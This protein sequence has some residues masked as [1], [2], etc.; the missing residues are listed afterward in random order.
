M[1]HLFLG[2]SALVAM[3]NA[4]PAAADT[5]RDSLI[6]AYETNP[7]L[8][9]ERA[10]LRAT[11]E[12][13]AQA[14]AQGRI[15]INASGSYEYADSEF[16]A[17]AV[18]NRPF[19]IAG[20]QQEETFSR[21]ITAEQPVFR[22]FR[23]LNA[24]RQA[25]AAIDAG[26]ANLL[27]VE[28]QVL[29]DGVTAYMDVLRDEAV[30]SLRENNVAVLD[31]QRQASKD[32]FEVGEVTRTDVAQA[33][34]RLA[35]AKAE[36]IAARANL[37]V[38]RAAFRRVIGNP[39][40]TLSPPPP[41]PELPETEEAAQA[42]ADQL[43]PVILTARATEVSS[44]RAVDVAKGALLPTLSARVEWSRAEEQVLANSVSDRTALIGQ[45][46]V[47]IFQ[48]GV[49]HSNVRQAKQQNSRDRMQIVA[50]DRDVEEQVRN[51][52]E[53]LAAARAA[54]LSSKE[55]VRANEIAFEGVEQEAQV[56]SRTTLDVLDAEQELLDSRVQLVQVERDEYVAGFALV[57]AI[58][59]LTAGG[60]G[61]DVDLYDPTRNTQRAKRRWVGFGVNDE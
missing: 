26:R 61:L 27:S 51:A 49:N 41:L 47:P 39:P 32:R 46:S 40:G 7:V 56:G 19:A 55:Q 2:A 53:N 50:A 17:G 8:K 21:Q 24:K 15:Q 57:S 34:A 5:L 38:S 9:S 13:A 45:L 1:K 6:A 20:E 43:N 33:E 23:T 30:V 25:D 10:N 16:K 12:Q 18:P 54:I 22:G 52:W 59:G 14:R 36:L 58:G 37:Q 28:Q 4:A 48:G 29:L 3:L 42:V 35:G 31:R 11:D 44:R 60:L